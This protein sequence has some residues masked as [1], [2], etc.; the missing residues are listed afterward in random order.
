MT[1]YLIGAVAVLVSAAVWFLFR[2]SKPTTAIAASPPPSEGPGSKTARAAIIGNRDE[3]QADIVADLDSD[4]PAGR[5][6]ER[7]NRQRK[8]RP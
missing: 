7:A 8:R 4:D 1:E 5:L 2:V 3:Q 6:A